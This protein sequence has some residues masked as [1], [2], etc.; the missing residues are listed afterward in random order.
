MNYFFVFTANK[1]KKYFFLSLALVFAIGVIYLERENINVFA[2]QE[3][4]AIY[5]INTEQNVIALTFD[6]SWGTQRLEPILQTLK[7]ENITS[8]TFFV[9]SVW[10]QAHPD[11]VQKIKDAG[12]EIGSHGHK[13]TNYSQL[14]DTE[15]RNQIQTA[16]SIIT[17][18]A[19]TEPNL[20]RL[21]NGDFDKRVLQI[22]NDLN[23]KVIQ[24]GT[25]AQD[26]QDVTAEQIIARVTE[27][28]HP[29]DIVLLHAS[30]SAKQTHL[31]LPSIIHQ[32]RADNYTFVSVSELLQYTE[33][34]GN[35]VTSK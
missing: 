12:Y 9:S 19:G 23:Y 27:Q 20:I 8:A 4:S 32:L 29:G 5:K 30:D 28:A 2:P 34:N 21:P 15:I 18:I 25:D 13:H 26:W 6:I 33:T 1:I 22:A 11:L 7:D 24:W 17:N 16:H 10:S 3:A 35:T 31:A 14:E